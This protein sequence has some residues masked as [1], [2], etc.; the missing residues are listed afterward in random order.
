MINEDV[1]GC[2]EKT[3]LTA[4]V[5]TRVLSL[6]RRLVAKQSVAGVALGAPVV[7]AFVAIA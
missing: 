1:C 7:V 3:Y 2:G 5:H 6:A 4:S